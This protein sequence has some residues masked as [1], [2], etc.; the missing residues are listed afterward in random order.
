MRSKLCYLLLLL[1]VA[2]AQLL[3]FL[4][5]LLILFRYKVLEGLVQDVPQLSDPLLCCLP[6]QQD[7]VD[8][9]KRRDV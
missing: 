4:L 8:Q 9:S 2:V 5:L 1:L 3:F 7:E 6:T